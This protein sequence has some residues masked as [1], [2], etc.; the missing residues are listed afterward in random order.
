MRIKGKIFGLGKTGN[1]GEGRITGK[2]W[3]TLNVKKK[4]G[5]FEKKKMNKT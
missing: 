5:N 4:R 3:N 1:I 2:L